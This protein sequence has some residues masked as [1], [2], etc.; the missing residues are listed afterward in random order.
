MTKPRSLNVPL[1]LLAFASLLTGCGSDNGENPVVSQ[2]FIHKYGYAVSQEEWNACQYPG[3]VITSMRDGVTVAAT[4]E[5]GELHGPTTYT[6]PHSQTVQAYYLYNRGN[7]VKEISYDISGMPVRERTQLSPSRYAITS[8]YL[9][10]T[11]LSI[12]EYSRDELMEGQYLTPHNETEAHVERGC[13]R[14]IRRS[15]EGLLL[16]VDQIEG[17]YVVRR[18]SFY[19][20]GA[21]ESIAH[22]VEGK[23]H[24]ELRKFAPSG[25]P[26]AMEEWVN[27]ELH[28][29]STYFK[30]GS[31][32]LE[33]S[34]LNGKKNGPELHYIDGALLSQEASWENDRRHGPTTYYVDETVATEWYYDGKQVSKMR[35]DELARLDAMIAEISP[36][37]RTDMR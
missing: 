11:P 17:G 1:T 20:S 3:Q 28:G 2:R 32:Y 22:F 16:S 5:N 21:P 10:G 36:E 6:F 14:R 19:A 37:V 34:Y 15:Q 8:W 27:G 4:Y 29:R 35:F 13:G 12:E 26:I 18:E 33:I 25:E 24:G 7:L 31:K 23:L 9:S 30:N